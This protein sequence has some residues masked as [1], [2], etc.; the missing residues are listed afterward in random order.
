VALGVK[1]WI[2]VAILRK[3][4]RRAEDFGIAS[5]VPTTISIVEMAALGLFL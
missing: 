5:I 3:S 2:F 4:Y 1:I